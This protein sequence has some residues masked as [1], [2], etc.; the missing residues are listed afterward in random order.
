M[1]RNM[2]P[3]HEIELTARDELPSMIPPKPMNTRTR[4]TALKE[5]RR[6]SNAP[7][8]IQ[9]RVLKRK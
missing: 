6:L 7:K 1:N 9:K 8:S 2:S 4:K 5:R 3:L